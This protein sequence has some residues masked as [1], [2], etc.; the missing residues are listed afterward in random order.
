M[1]GE[2][3]IG[4]HCDSGNITTKK[5]NRAQI[6]MRGFIRKRVD[7]WRWGDKD[8]IYLEGIPITC[9]SGKCH[10]LATSRYDGGAQSVFYVFGA[11]LFLKSL[12]AGYLLGNGGV[13][14]DTIARNGN[15]CVA[16]HVHSIDL[17]TNGGRLNSLLERNR[18]AYTKTNGYRRNIFLAM[19]VFLTN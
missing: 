18:G 3:S 16:T 19:S 4:V 10:R 2:F 5:R 15:S 13:D 9:S 12:A 8:N 17:V 7:W 14:I 11:S 6:G 1:G